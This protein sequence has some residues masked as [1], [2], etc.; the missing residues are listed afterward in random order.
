VEDC[1]IF[2]STATVPSALRMNIN[3]EL[4]RLQRAC[5]KLL[6]GTIVGPDGTNASSVPHTPG[7]SRMSPSS[8]GSQ[9]CAAVAQLLCAVLAHFRTI[10]KRDGQ[11]VES[12]CRCVDSYLVLAR[13]M[14]SRPSSS[15]EYLEHAFKLAT[16][17][18]LPSASAEEASLREMAVGAIRCISQAYWAEGTRLHQAGQHAAAI[19]YVARSCDLSRKLVGVWG[20]GANTLNGL[21]RELMA[22][23]LLIRWALLGF[24]Q[25]RTGDRQVGTFRHGIC[26]CFGNRSLTLIYSWLMMPTFKRC[27]PSNLSFRRSPSQLLLLPSRYSFAHLQCSARLLPFLIGSL[28][29]ARMIFCSRRASPC[30]GC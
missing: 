9:Y 8:A 3:E 11:G 17:L 23:Q 15:Y 21:T 6:K 4:E 12:V 22:E 10:S 18:T 27:S 5:T 1:T 14:S 30:L 20:E 16:A 28:L 2:I 19:P 29:S 26:V 24:C 25:R 13:S 7:A